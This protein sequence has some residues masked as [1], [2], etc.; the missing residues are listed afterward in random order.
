MDSKTFL[1]I[2]LT[3][4]ISLFISYFNPLYLHIHFVCDKLCAFCA[5]FFSFRFTIGLNTLIVSRL[6]FF[7]ITFDAHP[8]S[9]W[10][11]CLAPNGARQTE[12]HIIKRPDCSDLLI[13]YVLNFCFKNHCG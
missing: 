1:E 3:F 10:F 4:L 5:I 11:F 9:G 6:E 8:H 12:S 2:S 7:G 13:V